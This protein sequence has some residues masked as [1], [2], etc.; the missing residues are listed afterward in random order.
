MSDYSFHKRMVEN[1]EKRSRELGI[2]LLNTPWWHFLERFFISSDIKT[3]NRI[4]DLHRDK[5][6]M[7]KRH[8]EINRT[9]STSN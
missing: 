6:E 4:A 8:E 9:I 2:E 3:L 1:A 7:E 5:I